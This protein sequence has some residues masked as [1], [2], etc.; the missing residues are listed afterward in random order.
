M[1]KHKLETLYVRDKISEILLEMFIA[2]RCQ[3]LEK[4]F[5]NTAPY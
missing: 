2:S 4:Q 3:N 1:N 5:Q